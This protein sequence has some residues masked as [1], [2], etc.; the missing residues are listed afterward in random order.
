MI[1]LMFKVDLRTYRRTNDIGDKYHYFL[2]CNNYKL[3]NFKENF[4]KEILKINSCFSSL[5][6]NNLFLYCIS[7]NDKSLTNCTARYIYQLTKIF[8]DCTVCN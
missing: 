2:N 4:L 1:S 8:S 3:K 6:K 7:I 5:G